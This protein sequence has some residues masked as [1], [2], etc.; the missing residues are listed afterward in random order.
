M[1]SGASRTYGRNAS[2]HHD[3]D[4]LRVSE[5]PPAYRSAAAGV[6]LRRAGLALARAWYEAGVTV[7]VDGV[8]VS[9]SS[10][11]VCFMPGDTRRW[12]L[13]GTAVC[14]ELLEAEELEGVGEDGR[15]GVGVTAEEGSVCAPVLVVGG[16]K[17]EFGGTGAGADVDADGGSSSGFWTSDARYCSCRDARDA[18][19]RCERTGQ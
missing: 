9:G 11:C 14:V 7:A 4:P 5:L 6:M 2:S 15:E 12:G 18:V 1:K 13:A 19:R 8:G 10:E 17:E 3:A 16:C